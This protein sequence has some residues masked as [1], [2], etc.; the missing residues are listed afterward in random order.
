MRVSSSRIA[1]VFTAL[2]V[3]VLLA[4]AA[5]SAFA[6]DLADEAELQFQLGADRYKAND[7]R[8]ALEH[9]LASNRL[10]PNRNVVFN[11]A[12]TY[13][14]LREMPNAYR[15]YTIARD[16][17]PNP[18]TRK[19]IEDAIAHI[20]PQVAVLK[21]ETQPPGATIYID[22]KDL[23]ARG[24]TPRSLGLAAG[25]YKVIAA[26]DGYEEAS[27]GPFKVKVGTETPV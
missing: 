18:V 25:S 26:K 16:Q 6:D 20:A 12:H 11:I 24:E 22:R 10:V 3:F 27:A 7:F 4:F 21:I 2:L 17:E 9:F 1:A 19:K 14:Q 13:E 15:Y 8:G 5:R 23:G